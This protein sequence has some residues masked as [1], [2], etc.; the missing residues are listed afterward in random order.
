M[1][2][3]SQLPCRDTEI[4]GMPVDIEGLLEEERAPV[5]S[6]DLDIPEVPGLLN[7]EQEATLAFQIRA[8]GAIGEAARAR[9]IEC[10]QRLVYK[11]ARRF[12]ATGEE[13]GMTYDDLVQEGLIGLMRAVGKFEPERGYKFSTM[14][15][16]WI[17]QAITR[18]LDEHLSAVHIPTYKLGEL[19]KMLRAEQQ[20]QQ[21]LQRKP[22]DEEL[23]ATA[24]MTVEQIENLR[25]LRGAMDL[26][27]LD[28]QLAD[29]EEELTLGSLLAD[30]DEETE[31][32]ALTSASNAEL[33]ATLDAVLTAREQK[34]L[35]LRFGLGC[36]EH[37][38]EEVG[39]KLKITRER[40]RQ[41]EA[42][43]LRKLRQPQVRTKLSA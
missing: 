6:L 36:P 13:R 37:T 7:R 16:W 40:V 35:K 27:S 4:E 9:F 28:E 3:A 38:L 43:A 15:I 19:R 2:R 11:V 25:S 42:K 26:H 39:R 8:G 5:L 31:T 20:L 33:L 24:E 18:A 21:G 41:L 10:N 17:R 30:P 14:A 22:S 34:I 23:A 1:L 32:Q 29:H 12:I